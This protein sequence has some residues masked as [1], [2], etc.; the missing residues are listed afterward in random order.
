M[1]VRA[2][3]TDILTSEFGIDVGDL[4][5]DTPLFSSGL[6]DSLS[7]VR[8]LMALEGRFGLSI[9]PLDVSI[10]D[11]DNIDQIEHTVSRLQ[12]KN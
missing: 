10:D 12:P 9:S 6:L 3:I 2:E 4:A 1:S 7:S 5:G 11:V 8:L